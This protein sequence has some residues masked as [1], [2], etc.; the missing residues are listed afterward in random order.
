MKIVEAFTASKTGDDSKNEDAIVIT[1]DFIAVLDGVTSKQCPPI[2]G[3]TGGRFASGEVACLIEDFPVDITAIEAVKRLNAG[4][5]AAVSFKTQLPAGVEPPSV[6]AAIYSRALGQIWRVGDLALM[7]DG[8]INDGGKEVD[9]V[10]SAARAFAIEIALS[11]GR[12]LDDI[13]LHDIGREQIMPLLKGQHFFANRLGPYGYAVIDGSSVPEGMIEIFDVR[14]T[15]ELVMASDGY[16]EIFGT[17]AESE[18][19]LAEVLHEDPL[20]FRK[21]KSTK[22]L[23]PGNISFDDRTYVRFLTNG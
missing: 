4:L 17:L 22:G 5:R 8:V 14:E 6:V 15:R 1:P 2:D 13:A 23:Q 16:P 21:F 18:A 11:E 3:K 9:R 20:L 12:R 10:A 7:M 19:F